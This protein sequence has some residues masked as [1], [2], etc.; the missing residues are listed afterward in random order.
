VDLCDVGDS[1]F[2]T[3]RLPILAGRAFGSSDGAGSPPSAI[4]NETLA[5]TVWPGRDPLG[6]TLLWNRRSLTVV[7][8]AKDSKYRRLWEAP[9]PF[10]YISDRQFGSLRR[11]L[12]VRGGG[13]AASLASALRREIRSVA[14]DL[15]LSAVL[16]V[17]RYIGFSTLPQRVGGAVAGAL[18][19]IGLGLA[20]LGVSA[21]VAFSVSRRTREI[22]IRMALGARPGQVVRLEAARGGKTAAVGLT[23][24]LLAALLFSRLLTSLLFGVRP[25]DPLTYGAVALVLLALTLAASY[26]PARRA[27]RVD[28]IGAHRSE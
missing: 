17:R 9:R 18:G 21:Q 28:P 1:Y 19:G 2:A 11:D 12:V 25:A 5:R 22:G 27:A 7:G 13:A 23:L 26:A 3:M 14:R 10:L 24:G 16:P 4:V 8:V 6:R 20:A 15:A